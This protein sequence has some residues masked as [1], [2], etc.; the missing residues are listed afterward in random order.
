[1]KIEIQ[2]IVIQSVVPLFIWI[3]E[4]FYFFLFQFE[5]MRL[6]NTFEVLYMNKNLEYLPIIYK[7]NS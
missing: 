1:M 4:H 2:N 3:E 7:K 6:S 5:V